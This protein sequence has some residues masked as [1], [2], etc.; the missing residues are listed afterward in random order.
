MKVL[1]VPDM[2]CGVC[3]RRIK[4][5]FLEEHIQN[6]INLQKKTVTVHKDAEIEKAIE[7]LGDLGFEVKQLE[8]R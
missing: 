1:N 6:E 7:L 2:H 3:V 4:K 5:A 8:R